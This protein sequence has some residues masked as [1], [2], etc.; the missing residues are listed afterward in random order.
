MP[1]TPHEEAKVAIPYS[2]YCAL[3]KAQ[4]KL[5]FLV[6]FGVD[7]WDGFSE[8]M[9]EFHRTYLDLWED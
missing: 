5:R 9:E 7:N 8:A 3:L 4:A 2:E 1:M 6:K